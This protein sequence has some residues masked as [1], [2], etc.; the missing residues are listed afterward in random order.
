MISP[1]HQVVRFKPLA[2][3]AL[4]GAVVL[5]FSAPTWAW[6][7]R[8]I[9]IVV[10]FAPGGP[11]DTSARV[12]ADALSKQMDH[13][14]VIENIPG[15]GSV[16]GSNKAASAE[17]DGYTLL[18]GTASSMAIAPHLNP[19]VNYEPLKSFAPIS[20]VAA[21][22]FVLAAK[23]DLGVSTVAELVEL[24]QK[25]S[26]KLDYGSV[27]AGSIVHMTGAVFNHAANID[28]EHI[29][30]KGG[31]PM[32]TALLA[33]DIDYAFDTPTTII[34]HLPD[35]KLVALGA[36]GAERWPSLP[37]LPTMQEQGLDIDIA[38]WFGLLAPAGT[39]QD[40]IDLLAENTNAVLQKPEVAEAL[41]KAGFQVQP[42][43]P[44]EFADR[45]RQDGELW[46]NT[47]K[48]LNITLE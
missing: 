34:P 7:D 12:V 42:S 10:P 3:L 14:F 21:A 9:S 46:G 45:I 5:M 27:G 31:A 2:G 18:W 38:T 15:A 23:P 13:A 19:H 37:D 41:G 28:A 25:Q 47:I 26:E 39:P 22:P 33:G 48:T 17:P 30:Y 11:T 36:T 6:P 24:A 44:Q 1:R 8:P 4:A 16:V 32:I 43:S 20:Q 35:G 29:P 40:R